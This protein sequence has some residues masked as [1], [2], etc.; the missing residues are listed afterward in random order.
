LKEQALD[1]LQRYTSGKTVLT[2]SAIDTIRRALNQLP[3]S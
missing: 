3:D 1:A 2:D